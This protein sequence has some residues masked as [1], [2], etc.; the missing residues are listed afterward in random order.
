MDPKLAKKTVCDTLEA[1]STFVFRYKQY[2]CYR[3]L[4]S[5]YCKRCTR[6][7]G[8][9]EHRIRKLELYEAACSRLGKR[10]LDVLH[11]LQE[12]QVSRFIARLLLKQHQ[13]ELVPLFKSY[14]MQG[15]A[16]IG[17]EKSGVK[18]D[19][20]QLKDTVEKK[21]DPSKANKNLNIYADMAILFEMAD[22]KYQ[23]EPSKQFWNDYCDHRPM[24]WSVRQFEPSSMLKSLSTSS[25]DAGKENS[26]SQDPL[27]T[28]ATPRNNKTEMAKMSKST[29]AKSSS[30]L[31]KDEKV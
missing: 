25:K 20:T 9:F 16:V 27:Q 24:R 17:K 18:Q 12:L 8:C 30:K 21:F 15:M 29:P 19:K 7:R 13:R 31:I 4:R 23:P 10:D 28:A 3:F 14:R 6:C 22:V 1:S 11:L 26:K 2:M 5:I